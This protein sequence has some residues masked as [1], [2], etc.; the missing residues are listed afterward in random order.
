[1][2]TA[3]TIW[4]LPSTTNRGLVFSLFEMTVGI[5]LAKETVRWQVSLESTASSTQSLQ[6]QEANAVPHWLS[7]SWQDVTLSLR[8]L[9][10]MLCKPQLSGPRDNPDQHVDIYKKKL[11]LTTAW[12]E[13]LAKFIVHM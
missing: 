13:W 10:T 9:Q 11:Y 1:M 3:V 4:P 12:K 5:V 6:A 8:K 2:C 7:Q